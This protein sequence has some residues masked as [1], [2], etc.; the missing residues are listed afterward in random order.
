MTAIDDGLRARFRDSNPFHQLIG[1][2]LE[3]RA[4]GYARVRLPASERIRGGVAGSI[5]GG[6]LSAL[7]DVVTL[8]AMGTVFTERERAAGTA[9]LSVSYLR[10][11]L[12]AYVIA[13]GRVL[14]KGRTLAVVDVDMSDPD[15]KLVAKAR[16]SYALR[17]AEL[18]DRPG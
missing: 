3:E 9:E 18:A 10:P 13:E 5:H 11:A 12:G 2:E 15:G 17:P 7:A 8:A 1:I 4:A 16:V 14:K 6:V